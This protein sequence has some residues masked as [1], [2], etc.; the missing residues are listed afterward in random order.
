MAR[1]LVGTPAGRPPEWSFVHS[2]WGLEIGNHEVH[3]R[4]QP[5]YGGVDAACNALCD[6]AL[7]IDADWFLLVASDA[8]F[9]PQTL[10]RLLSWGV[11]AVAALSFTRYGPMVPTVYIREERNRD[12]E[13]IFAIDHP[14]VLEWLQAHPELMQLNAPAVLEPRP[15]DALLPVLRFGTHLSL[16]SREV[17]ETTGPGWFTRQNEDG[18][19]ED[20]A[21][22]AKIARAGFQPYVD[23]SVVG[24]HLWGDWA[25]TPLDY[26]I[27]AQSTDWRRH[28]VVIKLGGRDAKDQQG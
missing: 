5:G 10:A 15:E 9:H 12:G 17:L 4:A 22:V 24:G 23:L 27:W 18:S 25:I 1:I 2:L 13:P 28:E 26:M 7:D 8:V 21:F 20:F 16:Y 19:G 3:F 14:V 6:H 11:D